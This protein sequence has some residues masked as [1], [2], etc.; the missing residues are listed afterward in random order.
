[1]CRLE[2]LCP[3]GSLLGSV[4]FNMYSS[5]VIDII[6]TDCG[7][8]NFSNDYSLQKSFKP[9]TKEETDLMMKLKPCLENIELWMR[10]NRLKLNPNKTEFILFGSKA[11]LLK[12]FTNEINACG[13]KVECS[14]VV[15][16]LDVSLD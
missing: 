8:N 14:L 6:L 9:G 7:V 15:Q 4:L 11:Q 16:Y 2:V 3:S 10:Q 5:T 1:M 12:F 13:L